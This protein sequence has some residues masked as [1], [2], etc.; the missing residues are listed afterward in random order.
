ML[1][2]MC[3]PNER[4]AE[5]QRRSAGFSLESMGGANFTAEK[6][7]CWKN[8]LLKAEFEIANMEDYRAV[9]QKEIDLKRQED[10]D[11]TIMEDDLDPDD[12]KLHKTSGAEEVL[13]S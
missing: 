1:E 3:G 6:E 2:N 9:Q 8:Q 12:H 11:D 4:A 10:P 5:S 13:L 7:A